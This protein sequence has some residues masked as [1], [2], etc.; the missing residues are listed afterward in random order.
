[1]ASFAQP[2]TPPAPAQPAQTSENTIR[3]IK[4]NFPKI[5]RVL[6]DI[7]HIDP[8]DGKIYHYVISD[9]RK[10]RPPS[11]FNLN[12][13]IDVITIQQ[14]IGMPP[15]RAMPFNPEIEE[16]RVQ[17]LE[18]RGTRKRSHRHRSVHR[19]NTHK[20]SFMKK[21]SHKHRKKNKSHKKTPHGGTDDITYKIEN[22][23]QRYNGVYVKVNARELRR[24]GLIIKDSLIEDFIV[25]GEEDG[26]TEPRFLF[27]VG[28]S[29]DFFVKQDN[30]D[31]IIYYEGS[32]YIQNLNNGVG[33]Q[34]TYE[35]NILSRENE[36][37]L[38][39]KGW[40]INSRFDGSVD[41]PN[42]EVIKQ[43]HSGGGKKS[44]KSKKS[45]KYKRC[46]MKWGG[47]QGYAFNGKIKNMA[48]AT[49]MPRT[50]YNTCES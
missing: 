7:N 23:A 26:T 9:L 22:A 30:P 27:G 21:P 35:N 2:A 3:L 24:R 29:G 28:N 47:S 34:Y 41:V 10:D 17:G 16:R 36:E 42:L 13:Q 40:S 1:M 15:Q 18:G 19:K 46:S 45:R 31:I 48:L 11:I 49:P 43:R 20:S 33:E 37:G 32:W 39:Q 12:N 4:K 8:E 25:N 50:S 44:K 38:P 5:N 14:L 6:N